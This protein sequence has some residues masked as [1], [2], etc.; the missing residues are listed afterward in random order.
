M[1]DRE[2]ITARIL[3]IMEKEGHS[4][5]SFARKLGMSWTSANNIVSGRNMPS[6]ENIVKIIES[7]E[8]VDANWLIMGQKSTADVDKKNLYTIINTQQKTIES[9]QKT[10]DRLTAKLVQELPEQSSQK[11]ADVV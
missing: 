6:Y 5:S 7:F 4:V 10:I 2:S 1:E 8:W 3:Q 9:Q 11:V